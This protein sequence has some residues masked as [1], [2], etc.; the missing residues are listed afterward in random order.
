MEPQ[1]RLLY[2]DNIRFFVIMLVVVMQ[3]SLTYGGSGSWYYTEGRLISGGEETF[4]SF[5][6]TFLQSFFMGL[7]FLIAGYFVPGSYDRKGFRL[8][9]KGRAIRL[10]IPALLFMLL[11]DP[12]VRYVLLDDRMSFGAFYAD[13]I[14]SLRFLSGSGPLWFALALLA[15]S[16]VYA[17]SRRLTGKTWGGA[18]KK[19]SPG[20]AMLV[21]LILA[22]AL[23][24]FL[25]RI[26]FPVGTGVLGMPLWCFAQYIVLFI[27]GILAYHYDLFSQLSRGCTGLLYTWPLWGPGVWVA[28]VMAVQGFWRGNYAL[29]DGGG[30]WQSLVFSLWE[31]FS[32]V[33]MCAGLLVLF[34]DYLNTQNRLTQALSDSAFAVYFFHAPVV[35]GITLLFQPVDWPPFVKF[36]AMIPICLVACF[37]VSYALTKVPVLKKIL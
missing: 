29:L 18:S 26:P 33:A 15:F 30:T 14:T 4:F 36:A 20:A 16:L 2:I 32:A 12:I 1:K 35:V 37:T 11:F 6:Q 27:T 17:V 31:S 23:L 13:N 25:L 5:F 24:T 8:F 28:L 7:F 22:V 19:V 34:R 9:L 10:G 21:L 3:L